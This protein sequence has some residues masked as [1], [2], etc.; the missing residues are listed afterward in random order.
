M[1]GKNGKVRQIVRTGVLIAL[2]VALQWLTAPTSTF[3]GQYVTGTCVNCVLFVG[4]LLC[5]LYSGVVIAV[6][7]PFCAFLL[8]IGPQLLQIVP[9]IALGNLALVLCIHFLLGREQ[10]ALQQKIIGTV[11]AAFTKLAVLYIAVNMVLIPV[12][13]PALSEKQVATFMAMFS[14]PQMV[15][16]LLGGIVAQLILPLLKKV[17]KK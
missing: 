17:I 8:G 12:M 14:W 2:L 11:I 7:S 4:T 5:G 6:L 10:A 15:T 1:N 16:A 13:G 9:A 3:A